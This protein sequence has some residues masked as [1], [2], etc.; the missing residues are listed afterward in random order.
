MR[1]IGSNAAIAS[2]VAR[3]EVVIARLFYGGRDYERIL[4][5]AP[6]V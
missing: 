3:S 2:R 6:E 4:R 5:S 1:I